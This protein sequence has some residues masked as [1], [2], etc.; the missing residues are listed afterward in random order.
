[1]VTKRLKTWVL[2]LQNIL[3]S[4]LCYI[5]VVPQVNIDQTYLSDFLRFSAIVFMELFFPKSSYSI[6]SCNFAC[7]YQHST[8]YGTFPYKSNE[9]DWKSTTIHRVKH[10][11]FPPWTSIPRDDYSNNWLNSFSHQPLT[12]PAFLQSGR[13][14]WCVFLFFH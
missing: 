2:Y 1:M 9:H 10:D 4:D 11:V 6:D 8:F 5:T 12:V 7:N 14:K 13:W 3:C